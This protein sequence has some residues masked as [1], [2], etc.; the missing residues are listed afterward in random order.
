MKEPFRI[1]RL[2]E[3]LDHLFRHQAQ[4]AG[5]DFSISIDADVPEL[6]LA[7]FV[8]DS[9]DSDQNLSNGIKFTQAGYVCLT[10]KVVTL[11]KQQQRTRLLFQVSDSG[12]GIPAEMESKVFDRFR[13]VQGGFN[14]GFGGL[15]IGLATSREICCRMEAE[16]TYTSTPGS[17]APPSTLLRNF[18]THPRRSK[19]ARTTRYT[20]TGNRLRPIACA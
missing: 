6:A 1:S 13:Q 8:P 17:M 4:S 2:A 5:L 7:I 16:L 15:G 19:M 11:D 14:R 20:M 18:P 12:I 10:V 9:A 3:S